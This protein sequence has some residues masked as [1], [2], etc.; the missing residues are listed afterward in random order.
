MMLREHARQIWTAA[1]DAVRPGPLLRAAVGRYADVLRAAPRI[2][3]FG[4]GKAGSAMALALEE[5]ARRAWLARVTHPR[6]EICIHVQVDRDKPG[7]SSI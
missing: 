5:A 7:R 6:R 1:V 2:V 3:V 4:G